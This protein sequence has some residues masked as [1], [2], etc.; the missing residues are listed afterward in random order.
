MFGSVGLRVVP[1]SKI[2]TPSF[3]WSPQTFILTLTDLTNY[4]TM[5]AAMF[6]FILFSILGLTLAAAPGW[7]IW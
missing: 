1:F 7:S 5:K 6:I 3:V 4:N 2:F